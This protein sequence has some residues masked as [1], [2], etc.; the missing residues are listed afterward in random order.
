MW[1]KTNKPSYGLIMDTRGIPKKG[2]EDT[3]PMFQSHYY[4]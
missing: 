2:A 4:R 3:A 1:L